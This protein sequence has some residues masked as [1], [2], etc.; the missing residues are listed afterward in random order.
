MHWAAILLVS[1]T[2]GCVAYRLDGWRGVLLACVAN[3]TLSLL[4]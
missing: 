1:G 2:I 4:A 3:V